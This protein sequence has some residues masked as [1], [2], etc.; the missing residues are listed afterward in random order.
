MIRDSR[1]QLQQKTYNVE[2][3]EQIQLL[4]LVKKTSI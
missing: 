4:R 1:K 2:D 3:A